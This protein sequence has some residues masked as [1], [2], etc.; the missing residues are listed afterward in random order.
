MLKNVM[1]KKQR[2]LSSLFKPTASII[3]LMIFGMACS[4]KNYYFV[5]LKQEHPLRY[6]VTAPSQ[7][8]AYRVYFELCKERHFMG[9]KILN[10]PLIM[11]DDYN[12]TGKFQCA[13]TFDPALALGYGRYK[14]K[15]FYKADPKKTTKRFYYEFSTPKKRRNY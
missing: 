11:D 2:T 5:N 7:K 8:E 6:K 14:E 13:G 1:K 4:Q 15:F 12:F 9:F 10:A 3:F